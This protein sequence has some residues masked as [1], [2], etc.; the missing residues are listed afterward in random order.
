MLD[1]QGGYAESC[2]T[3]GWYSDLL[4]SCGYVTGS[5]V[6][7]LAIGNRSRSRV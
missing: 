4:R 5:H 7:F 2:Q 3:R 6:A 1:R